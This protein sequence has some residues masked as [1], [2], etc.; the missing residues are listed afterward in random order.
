M[1]HTMN[2]KNFVHTIF[3][4]SVR[5]NR[6]MEAQEQ[7]RARLQVLK[8][9]KLNREKGIGDD[10]AYRSSYYDLQPRRN[11]NE[12]PDQVE[13]WNETQEELQ[14]FEKISVNEGPCCLSLLQ[15]ASNGHDGCVKNH[16][17]QTEMK[18]SSETDRTSLQLAAAAGHA[19]TVACIIALD[20]SQ[21]LLHTADSKGNTALHVA[22]NDEILQLLL[23]QGMDPNGVNAKGQTAAHTNIAKSRLMILVSYHADLSILDKRK[24]NALFYACASQNTDTVN[25]LCTLDNVQDMMYVADIHGDTPLHACVSSP[26]GEALECVDVLL[27]YGAD[28]WQ[29]NQH[30]YTA[31]DIAEY[32]SSPECTEFLKSYQEYYALQQN[33]IVLV[34]QT[35]A[36]REDFSKLAKQQK[37]YRDYAKL[38]NHYDDESPYRNIKSTEIVCVLCHINTVDMVLMPCEHKCICNDCIYRYE[39]GEQRPQTEKMIK[40]C[41][42]CRDRIS[43]AVYATCHDHLENLRYHGND[44]ILPSS[45]LSNFRKN[46][47]LLKK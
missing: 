26:S 18:N 32:Y 7:L 1:Y 40:K 24:Q 36:T 38:A 27:R 16:W 42:V 25:Y 19:D 28:P 37:L 11:L 5:F 46:K 4:F 43:K 41:P 9:R 20:T 2:T 31:T 22:M 12:Y 8:Q 30:G 33:A 10:S 34:D 13:M 29:Y 14:G 35:C 23:P 47:S 45:F 39:I 21:T 6:I 44:I 17:T 15:A 3:E